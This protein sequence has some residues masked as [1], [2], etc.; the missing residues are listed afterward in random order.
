M[1]NKNFDTHEAFPEE[2]S[3]PVPMFTFTEVGQLAMLVSEFIDPDEIEGPDADIMK[4]V[5]YKARTA[6]TKK[7]NGHF[8][9][10]YG[11]DIRN[12]VR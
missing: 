9:A 7:G 3:R 12:S 8:N 11:V 1:P 10:H 2:R 4:A 6:I 5:Y